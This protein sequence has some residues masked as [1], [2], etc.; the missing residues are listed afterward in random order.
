[1]GLSKIKIS[2]PRAAARSASSALLRAICARGK[3]E[4][5]E[6]QGREADGQRKIEPVVMADETRPFACLD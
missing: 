3:P 6:Q 5:E 4:R 1:M 2:T